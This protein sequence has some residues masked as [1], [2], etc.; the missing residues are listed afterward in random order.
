[1]SEWK[2]GC[3]CSECWYF[4]P[5]EVW[6]ETVDPCWPPM[7]CAEPPSCSAWDVRW[8]GKTFTHDVPDDGFCH[9]WEPRYQVKQLGDG[10]PFDCVLEGF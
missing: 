2:P 5:M 8:D 1:M 7:E 4:T 3:T 9:K 6:Y 10:L